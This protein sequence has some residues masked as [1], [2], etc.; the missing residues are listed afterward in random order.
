[1]KIN[2]IANLSM[3]EIE[4]FARE[5]LAKNCHIYS[6]NVGKLANGTFVVKIRAMQIGIGREENQ[7]RI[8][9]QTGIEGVQLQGESDAWRKFVHN[10]LSDSYKSKYI[11]FLKKAI[12]KD[13][14]E[15]VK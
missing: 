12:K 15:L 9:T 13:C 6:L 4:L 11:K 1:M 5:N 3:K 2:F 14:T 10:K 8:L 7:T